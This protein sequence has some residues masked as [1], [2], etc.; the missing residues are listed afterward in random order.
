MRTELSYK[1]V[2]AERRLI[3]SGMG[4]LNWLLAKTLISQVRPCWGIE[5]EWL[6]GRSLQL[7]QIDQ[8]ED[9]LWDGPTELVS[10]QVSVAK[11]H[12]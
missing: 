12:A 4:P 10:A 6:L 1:S 5:T 9:C 2:S 7:I 11:G 8:T 3:P